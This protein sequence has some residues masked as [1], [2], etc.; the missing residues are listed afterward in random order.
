MWGFLGRTVDMS[1]VY[2]KGAYDWLI[3]HQNVHYVVLSLMVA[4]TAVLPF[5]AQLG[6]DRKDL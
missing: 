4:L 6:F 5:L 3:T 2:A 1:P